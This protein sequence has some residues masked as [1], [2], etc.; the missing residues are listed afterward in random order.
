M[1]LYQL[2]TSRVAP[3]GLYYNDDFITADEATALQQVLPVRNKRGGQQDRSPSLAPSAM[4]NL[5]HSDAILLR[6]R[7][8]I[9]AR[10]KLEPLELEAAALGLHER[11]RAKG[12]HRHDAGFDFIAEIPV[13]SSA[14]LQ[15]RRCQ[16]SSARRNV[17]HE[18]RLEPRSLVALEGAARWEWQHRMIAPSVGYWSLIFRSR[19]RGSAAI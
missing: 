18:V 16:S 19:L 10:F 12:W 8:R 17:Q 4:P 7:D 3:A 11:H 15:F 6:L 2:T 14:I 9:S 5:D 13:A 1:A